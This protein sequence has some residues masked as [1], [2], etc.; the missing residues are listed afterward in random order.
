MARRN[1]E[2]LSFSN[3]LLMSSSVSETGS[4]SM[5]S[6]LIAGSQPV[7]SGETRCTELVLPP[8][9]IPTINTL[10]HTIFSSFSNTTA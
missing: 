9:P 3:L 2:C 6:L 5:A 8:D 1:V 10:S 7:T 4:P